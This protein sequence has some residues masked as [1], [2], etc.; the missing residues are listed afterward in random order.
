MQPT[1][2][3]TRVGNLS[4]VSKSFQVSR[5]SNKFDVIMRNK[6]VASTG[7]RRFSPTINAIERKEV[8]SNREYSSAGGGQ[9]G[10]TDWWKSAFAL[11]S[12]TLH[13]ALSSLNSKLDEYRSQVKEQNISSRKAIRNCDWRAVRYLAQKSQSDL[14]KSST[15]V[16]EPENTKTNWKARVL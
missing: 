16:L 9:V 4:N 1:T 11:E 10:L 15:P 3:R 12:D 14:E 7:N 13:K 6:L 5:R 8:G 2:T